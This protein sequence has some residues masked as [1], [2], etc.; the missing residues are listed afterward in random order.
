MR[1]LS[2]CRHS[3]H[4]SDIITHPS[5]HLQTMTSRIHHNSFHRTAKTVDQTN[6]ATLTDR[7]RAESWNSP[8]ANASTTFRSNALTS[9]AIIARSID[10]SV[11]YSLNPCSFLPFFASSRSV[12]VIVCAYP[13]AELTIIRLH[14]VHALFP[15]SPSPSFVLQPKVKQLAAPSLPNPSL[16]PSSVA[17]SPSNTYSSLLRAIAIAIAFSLPRSAAFKTRAKDGRSA[18]MDSAL[19]WMLDGPR[20]R[21][22]LACGRGRRDVARCRPRQSSD[23]SQATLRLSGMAAISSCGYRPHR[24][25]EL[26]NESGGAVA[27]GVHCSNGRR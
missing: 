24:P 17:T 20:L 21:G 6:A 27:A 18:W 9:A 26:R 4:L 16:P 3:A 14:Y 22:I 25:S 12:I 19:D 7:T 10:Q 5:I 23:S 1:D 11:T 2:V 13:A 15:S 8:G